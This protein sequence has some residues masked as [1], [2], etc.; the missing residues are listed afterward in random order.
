MEVIENNE[1]GHLWNY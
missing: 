1:I